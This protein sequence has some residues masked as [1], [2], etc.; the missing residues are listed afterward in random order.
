MVIWEKPGKFVSCWQ[1][2]YISHQNLLFRFNQVGY[3]RYFSYGVP[4]DTNCA[5]GGKCRKLGKMGSLS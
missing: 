2:Q 1:I 4:K 5:N 3:F